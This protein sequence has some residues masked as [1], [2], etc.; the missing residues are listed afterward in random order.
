MH[1]GLRR[2]FLLSLF[3]LLTILDGPNVYADGTCYDPAVANG[4]GFKDANAQSLVI[5]RQKVG[6]KTIAGIGAKGRYYGCTISQEAVE[7]AAKG[8]KKISL[9]FHIGPQN[10]AK[11]STSDSSTIRGFEL[12]LSTEGRKIL[13][14]RAIQVP[15]DVVDRSSGPTGRCTPSSPTTFEGF[16]YQI[17]REIKA[18]RCTV[19]ELSL[20]IGEPLAPA[21]F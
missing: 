10:K 3:L 14:G 19:A 2:F 21:R 1:S 13:A 17:L 16:L 18:R 9:F 4:Y 7:R 20:L 6:G 5:V 12:D 11:D 8:Q 15:W